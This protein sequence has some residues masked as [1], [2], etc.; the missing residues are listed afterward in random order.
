MSRILALAFLLCCTAGAQ[1]YSSGTVRGGTFWGGLT[2]RAS[3]STNDPLNSITNNMVACWPLDEATATREDD[4]A[5]F[6]LTDNNTVTGTTGP[7]GLG[8]ASSFAAANSESLSRA[9]D[10]AEL[11]MGDFSATFVVWANMGSTV[12]DLPTVFSKSATGNNGYALEYNPATDKFQFV[13]AGTD[14]IY[15]TVASSA[16]FAENSGWHFIVCGYDKPNN[17]IF[18]SVDGGLNTTATMSGVAP[19]AGTAAFLMGNDGSA[20]FNYFWSGGIAGAA[21]WD[22]LLSA[23]EREQLYAGGDGAQACEQE[24]N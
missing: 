3:A 1:V 7:I 9:G 5:T 2:T 17:L 22:R 21:R 20:G 10:D 4:W 23:I 18:I 16:T 13:V 6:D 24:G 12:S 15:R 11:R 14:V 19:R 8:N